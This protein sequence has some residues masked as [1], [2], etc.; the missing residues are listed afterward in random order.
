MDN[1]KRI[2]LINTFFKVGGIQSSLINMANELCEDYQ[3]DLLLYYPEGP[4]K[5]RLDSKVNII[6]P[7]WALKALGMSVSEAIKSKNLLIILFKIWGSVWARVFDNRLPIWLASKLQPKLKGYDL[8]VAFRQEAQKK[9]LSS[10]FVRVL[11]RCVDAK[12]K[13]AW[14]HY[15]A[16]KINNDNDFNNK[17][18][19]KADKVIGVSRSV[20]K[21]FETLNSNLEG[22]TDYCYNFLDYKKIIEKSNE[23]QDVKYPDDKFICFS[24]CRLSE[25]KGLIRGIEAFAPALRKHRDVL[26]YI[27]GDGPER[28]NIESAIKAEN[29]EGRIILL[30]NQSNPYPYMKNADLYLSLSF[31]EAA[32][33]VYME[34]KALHVP[35]FSTETSSSYEM[36][37]DGV[38]DFICKNSEEGIRIKF[39][40]VL[41]DRDNIL[42]AKKQLMEYCA[43][44]SDSSKRI[45]GWIN[46]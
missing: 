1:R 41:N 42:A 10:G 38:E 16:L 25:E 3:V 30:G 2:L 21:S 29:L 35:V 20:V 46:E 43:G 31:H 7:S 9:V 12:Y 5:D 45:Y 27:A 19:A 23:K 13:F 22:K 18:Y 39:N 37:K 28:E 4:L 17:Y 26:W 36:L 44:N 34:A 40:E 6:Q 33:M 15:D 8:A 14:I 32:P 11:T 24:A